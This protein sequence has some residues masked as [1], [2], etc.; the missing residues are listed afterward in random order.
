MQAI[1]ALLYGHKFFKSSADPG[2]GMN[3]LM[4]SALGSD[5]KKNETGDKSF[6]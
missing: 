2:V 6:D 4:D 1:G 3:A 5:S